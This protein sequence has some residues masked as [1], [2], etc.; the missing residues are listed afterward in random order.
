MMKEP[1]SGDALSHLISLIYDCALEPERWPDTL[2]YLRHALD[3]ANASLSL[4]TLPSG[5]VLID[6]MSSDDPIWI[7]R[8]PQSRK[9]VLEIWGGEEK[10]QTYPMGEPLVLSRV[11]P[12]S[13][14]ENSRYIQD[15]AK[16]HGIHDIL[17]IG[18]ARDAATLGSLAFGRH[19]SA[20]EIEDLEVQAAR[21]LAPHLRRAV[22]ISRLLEARS[23]VAATF[24]TALD[25]LGVAIVLTDADLRIVHA[26]AAGQAM[27]ASRDPIRREDGRLTLRAT[28]AAT[29][30]A[31][32]VRQAVE[33][34]AAI[35]QR[36]IGI[37]APRGDG[38]P[39]LLHVLP[40]KR[41]ELRPG[42]A[43]AAVAAIFVAPADSPPPAAEAMAALFDLTAAE[44][45][46]FE[47]IVA[48]RTV[49]ET[50]EALGIE[51]T[52]T[53]THLA[54]IFDKTGTHRQADLVRLSAALALPLRP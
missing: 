3:F 2:T 14:W 32:A 21:L 19:T 18:L 22:A 42:L 51:V 53:K 47:Q 46:V 6:N 44:T 12:R 38:A 23:V 28:A 7:E 36:G 40:L 33:N 49:L 17:A 16:P 34:E 25:T 37:P 24:A 39:C 1:L 29:A 48:G 4:V 13:E 26:N 41:G 31:L 15:W 8:A 5:E 43:P 35:G 20:G 50:A 11:R 52:T 54:H 45:R 30:L 10:V 27:L 9:E